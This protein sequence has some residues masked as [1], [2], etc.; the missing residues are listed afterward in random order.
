MTPAYTPLVVIITE[1]KDTAVGFP[2]VPGGIAVEGAGTGGGTAAAIDWLRSCPN[3]I[4]WGDMDAD[5]LAILN[6]HREAGLAVTSILMD[7]PTYDT[8]AAFGTNHDIKGNP[9]TVST[10]RKLDKLT[11]A[12]RELYDRLTDPAWPGYRRVEQERI[13]LNVALDAV[14]AEVRMARHTSLGGRQC[15]HESGHEN[16]AASCPLP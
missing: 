11:H 14:L 5:G 10:R 6:Q 3:V 15:L 1:N 2:Q 16:R 13:P 9:I 7:I 4:Y 12:E 8:Y